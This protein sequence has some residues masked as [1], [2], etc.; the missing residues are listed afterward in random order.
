MKEA[1]YIAG[2]MFRGLSAVLLVLN[3]QNRDSFT[4]RCA[5]YNVQC[6]MYNVQCAMCNVQ[7]KMTL[8][9]Q[10]HEIVLC[11]VTA[12]SYCF[13]NVTYTSLQPS[14]NIQYAQCGLGVLIQ[15]LNQRGGRIRNDS[16]TPPG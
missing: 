8:I 5:M 6:T 4:A 16:M 1:L 2:H 10:N 12:T 3:I 9:S 7:C 11:T 15:D 13:I 14:G